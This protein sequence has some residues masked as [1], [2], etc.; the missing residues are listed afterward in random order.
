MEKSESIKEI[1]TAL[2]AFQAGMGKIKKEENNPFF[3]SKYASLAN[4]IDAVQKPLADAGLTYSQFPDEESLTTILMHTSG[5]WMASS[6]K[7]APVKNDPQ[8]WGSA[9][10]Y[11]RRYALSGILGLNVDDDDDGNAASEPAKTATPRQPTPPAPAP[12]IK[13]TDGVFD[14]MRTAVVN[15]QGDDVLDRI[16]EKYLPTP[17]QSE[18]IQ[19]LILKHSNPNSNG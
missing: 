6:Y 14:A 17:A 8:G 10:T 4:I 13:I 5:E 18:E 9:I 1:A 19:L 3:K 2:H 15:G 11:A 16:A 7:L 12:K